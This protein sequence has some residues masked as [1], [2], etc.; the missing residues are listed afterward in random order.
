MHFL[1]VDLIHLHQYVVDLNLLAPLLCPSA[2]LKKLSD[3][4]MSLESL[5]VDQGP[6]VQVKDHP[7]L[8][9][10]L[11]ELS[12]K[13]GVLVAN[14]LQRVAGMAPLSLAFWV[15]LPCILHVLRNMVHAGLP[16]VPS[17]TLRDLRCDSV[18][19]LL[20]LLFALFHCQA[21]IFFFFRHR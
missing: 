19:A 20:S 16:A 5:V 11:L 18:E 8:F 4:L 21:I 6:S 12:S 1:N 15:P 7:L 3:V 9:L 14:P 17:F 2:N 10:V 13:L